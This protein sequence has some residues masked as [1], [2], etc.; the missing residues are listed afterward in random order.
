MIAAFVLILAVVAL[1]AEKTAAAPSVQPATMKQF[2]ILFRQGPHPLTDADKTR[3]QAA[4]SAWARE[5][6]E[7]YESS[8]GTEGTRAEKSV[9]WDRAVQAFP[10]YAEYQKKTERVIP[11]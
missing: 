5:Q 2:I 7:L 6:A 11:L 10:D 9:W 3:R 1:P 8:G 4:I